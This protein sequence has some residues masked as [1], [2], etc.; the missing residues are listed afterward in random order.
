MLSARLYGDDAPGPMSACSSIPVKIAVSMIL[1][2]SFYCVQ[3]IK[4]DF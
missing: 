1:G 3:A 4:Q 2:Y